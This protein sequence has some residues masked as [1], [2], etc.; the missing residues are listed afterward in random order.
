MSDIFE[1]HERREIRGTL[2]SLA[3]TNAASAATKATEMVNPY[4]REARIWLRPGMN[5]ELIAKTVQLKLG[6]LQV[7]EKHGL[8]YFAPEHATTVIKLVVDEKNCVPQLVNGR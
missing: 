6:L 8:L 7:Q 5:R 2:I 1:E 3:V 4:T